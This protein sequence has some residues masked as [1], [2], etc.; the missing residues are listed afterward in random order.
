MRAEK[1]HRKLAVWM[2]VLLA[3][4]GGAAPALARQPEAASWNLLEAAAEGSFQAGYSRGGDTQIL[5]GLFP[6]DEEFARQTLLVVFPACGE[7]PV[8]PN[9]PILNL[10]EVLKNP[11]ARIERAQ[12]WKS[13]EPRWRLCPS[14]SAFII[15][16]GQPASVMLALD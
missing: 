15:E 9:A 4:T 13:P 8:T 5:I 14:D 16:G 6:S 7:D 11:S 2:V 10:E 12:D 3:A 1:M